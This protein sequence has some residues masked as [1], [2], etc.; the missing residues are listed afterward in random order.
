MYECTNNSHGG[1]FHI[2]RWGGGGRLGPHIK[3]GSKFVARS[4]QVHQ[5]RGRTWE[6]YHKMQKLGKNPNFGVISEIHGSQ[7]CLGSLDSIQRQ[8]TNSKKLAIKSCLRAVS[9]G[10]QSLVKLIQMMNEK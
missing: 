7:R 4:S 6:V 3:F 8:N 9:E 5:I 2:R 10:V 1:Y